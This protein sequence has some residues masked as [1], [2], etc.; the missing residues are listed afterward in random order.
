MD[1]VTQR[2]APPRVRDRRGRGMRGPGV[3]PAVPGHRPLRRPPGSG[4]TSSCSTSSRSSTSAG[5]DQLGLVEYAVEDA[6]MLPDDWDADTVPLSSLVRGK[7]QAARPGWCSS[8]AP[9]S[10]AASRATSWRRWCS[11]WSSSRWPS[12]S[13]SA[14]GGRP[15]LHRLSCCQAPALGSDGRRAPRLVVSAGGNGSTETA[16]VTDL[17]GHDR[18]GALDADERQHRLVGQP[19]PSAAVA[20][21][22]RPGAPSRRRPARPHDL[23]R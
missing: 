1:D 20:G 4:S 2:G 21:R 3:L 6:P 9:S 5:S 12:C 11:P 7:G 17:E 15:A 18:V 22:A 8:A 16:A 10:T 19:E 14:R 13:A 23:R